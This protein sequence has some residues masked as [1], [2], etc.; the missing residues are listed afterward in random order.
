MILKVC[1]AP[2][3]SGPV[4]LDVGLGAGAVDRAPWVVPQSAAPM[5][6]AVLICATCAPIPP[7]DLIAFF[8]ARRYGRALISIVK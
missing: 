1:K 7:V 6:S 4:Q 2:H 8:A 5:L 3:C